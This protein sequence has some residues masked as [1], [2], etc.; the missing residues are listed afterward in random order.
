MNIKRL[1]YAAIMCGLS[2]P[3]L[4][5]IDIHNMRMCPGATELV[6][7]RAASQSDYCPQLTITCEVD[8]E[9]HIR[10]VDKYNAWIDDCA[11]VLHAQPIRQFQ[12][13]PAGQQ[14]QSDTGGAAEG[15]DTAHNP[16]DL[17]DVPV[18]LDTR[19]IAQNVQ[20]LIARECKPTQ[21][22][23][24][25]RAACGTW[26]GDRV[27]ND[28]IIMCN[29]GD[30]SCAAAKRNDVN[31]VERQDALYNI[32]ND[33]LIKRDAELVKGRA[34]AN[35]RAR[36]LQTRELKRR[37]DA[38]DRSL[39]EAEQKYSRPVQ[40]YTPPAEADLGYPPGCR[41][42]GNYDLCA[43]QGQGCSLGSRRGCQDICRGLCNY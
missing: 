6:K 10:D 34:A 35:E 32:L 31:E 17:K 9:K 3:A 41:N 18:N 38:T 28:C 15:K 25:C 24:G 22:G 12:T 40:T 37:Q 33:R 7:V 13:A 2:F 29:Y 39:R 16:P 23:S 20:K 26:K 19:P 8:W 36:E 11:R 30:A 27:Y 1:L 5:E 43:L 4:A 14:N 21:S 42:K